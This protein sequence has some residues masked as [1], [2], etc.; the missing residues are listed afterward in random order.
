MDRRELLKL[1]GGAAAA[2]VVAPVVVRK[3]DEVQTPAV[4]APFAWSERQALSPENLNRWMAE[5]THTVG[6]WE[7][8]TRRI[9]K[10]HIDSLEVHFGPEA[11]AGEYRIQRRKL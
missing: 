7:D 4:V 6:G 5:H 1:L 3:N 8:V 2:A 9:H 11:P 10:T